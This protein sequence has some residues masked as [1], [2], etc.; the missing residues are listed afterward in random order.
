MEEESLEK[1]KLELKN[2]SLNPIDEFK[3]INCPSCNTPVLADNI[4]I[5][6]KIAKCN[7]CNVVF[8]IHQALD[9][10][11]TKNLKQEVLRPEGID[12]FYYKDDLDITLE[13]PNTGIEAILFFFLSIFTLIAFLIFMKGKISYIFPMVLFLVNMIPLASLLFRTKRKIYITIDEHYLDIKWRPKNFHKD[14][15][16]RIEEIDQ[17]YVR[18]SDLGGV[19]V[20]MIVN[21][22]NGQKH[23]EL[24]TGLKSVSKARYLEQEIEHYLGI[25]DRDIPEESI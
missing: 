23:I 4:N 19:A 21:G 15:Q 3:E 16:Y 2:L 25:E 12:I 14:K 17:I 6:D 9:F 8:P 7:N 5:N 24:I 18:K 22:I 1:Y 13:Q 11:Q 10:K 20:M